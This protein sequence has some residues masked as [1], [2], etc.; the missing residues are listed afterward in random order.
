[1]TNRRLGRERERDGGALLFGGLSEWVLAFLR[2]GIL[3]KRH[4]LGGGVMETVLHMLGLGSIRH[5]DGCIQSR[6]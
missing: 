3:E 1:M 2:L 5:P 4:M 6:V